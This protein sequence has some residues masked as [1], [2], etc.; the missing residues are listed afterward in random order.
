MTTTFD[1]HLPC[2]SPRCSLDQF[3][4]GERDEP[5]AGFRSV[6]DSRTDIGRPGEGALRPCSLHPY[7]AVIRGV[8]T[9]P[10]GVIAHGRVFHADLG[11]GEPASSCILCDRDAVHC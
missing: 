1:L 9:R 11:S 5:I 10:F 7:N 3:D 2:G 8:N 6:D 4:G